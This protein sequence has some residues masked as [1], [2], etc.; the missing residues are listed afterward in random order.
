MLQLLGPTPAWQGAGSAQALPNTL[1]GWMVALLALHDG[2]VARERLLALLWPHAPAAEAQHNL[3]VNL[4]RTKALLADWGQADAL[5]TERRRVQLVLPNDVA[6]LR[7]AL[8]AGH[9]PASVPGRLLQGMDFGAF[10]GLREWVEAEGRELSQG[11]RLALLAGMERPQV[12]APDVE[13]TCRLLLQADALDEVAL[14]R[15]LALLQSQARYAELDEALTSYCQRLRSE[16]GVEPS[17]A[18]LA[19]AAAS[20]R[21]P[22]PWAGA[23]A[24]A[25]GS[26]APAGAF[27]GRRQELLHITQALQG[28]ARW[29]TLVGPGGIGKS[30]LAR[31]VVALSPWPALWV[32]W[33]E[34][35]SFEAALGRLAQRLAID[36]DLHGASSAAEQI[37]KGLGDAP[38]LVVLDNAEP[39]AE[40][41]GGFLQAVLAAVPGLRVLATSRVALAPPQ[42]AAS[43]Q[44]PA[45]VPEA[46]VPLAGLAVPDADSHDAEAAAAFDAVR[47]FVLRAQAVRHGFELAPHVQAVVEIV[48]AVGGHPLAI[49]LA[50]T[51]VRLLPPGQI[52][53]DLR[54]SLALLAHDPVAGATL[55]RA[56]HVSV[57]AVLA[58]SW[59]L[60]GSAERD[61]VAALTVF[62]GGFTAEAA[63]AVAQVGLPML[64]RLLSQALVNTQDGAPGSGRF[65]LH[66]LV[67][68]Q[69][70]QALDATAEAALR[71][72][73]AQHY[74]QWL[75]QWG[76][77]PPAQAQ[78]FVAALEAELPN[79]EAAWQLA[80]QEALAGRSP[81][82][83]DGMRWAWRHH[84]TIT[85]RF[86][87][88][89]ARLEPA[90]AVP[91]PVLRAWLLHD[92]AR[93]LA[94]LSRTDRAMHL[95]EQA[96]A[97]AQ[98]HDQHALAQAC[99]HLLGA[100]CSTLQRFEQAHRWF[101]EALR[102]AEFLAFPPAK[103]ATTRNSLS[104]ACLWLHRVD[105]ALAHNAEVIRALQPE[106][107]SMELARAGLN[108]GYMLCC[109]DRWAEGRDALRSGWRQAADQGYEA[110]ARQFE[111]L[112]ATALVELRELD[113]AAWH[114]QRLHQAFQE[115][116]DPHYTLKTEV[117]LARVAALRGEVATAGVQLLHATR[118]CRQ[119][120]YGEDR[121]YAMAYLAEALRLAGHGAA[122][123]ALLQAAGQHPGAQAL[124]VA[125]AWR[126]QLEPL[127]AM[128]VAAAAP[129]RLSFE[130]AQACI[131]DAQ[132]L[133]DLAARL[134]S[135]WPQP[136]GAPAPHP[137]PNP[138]LPGSATLHKEDT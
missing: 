125:Q 37:A 30:T 21:E 94:R 52:A 99:A 56:E 72:R 25:A 107:A 75:A 10:A 128:A 49:E 76:E 83:L 137:D 5:Q 24:D 82:L 4:H 136:A 74:G 130:V 3:R 44:A 115:V 8:D 105:E 85:G 60:L 63:Q 43:P 69:G 95:V 98:A 71:L 122:A 92:L 55:Q 7:D 112:L 121:F 57:Q 64:S 129:P 66:P 41:A 18:V 134:A 127:H 80:L 46:T 28:G 113:S 119:R 27:V 62:R 111:F 89:V 11:W 96:V 91:Q 23:S 26:A 13:A 51:W 90:T 70:R 120:G 101:S 133:A 45:P 2:W 33:Q 109:T 59:A 126:L 132:T 50:A 68:V 93:L 48:E 12:P 22:P 32:D 73:H 124:D 65:G 54:D 78:A 102:L 67:T 103:A 97:L 131:D 118:T 35:G 15:L 88:G 14:L 77:A 20:G 79:A 42:A 58:R 110:L 123:L 86:A 6:T 116:R 40:A 47:L 100:I 53:Q 87:Q 108:R 104:M 31:R 117:Y 39:V 106:G 29:V 135:G 9:P 84:S 114:L 81:A 34:V 61:A 1:P 36:L 138:P 19:L 16:L 38:R 17:A